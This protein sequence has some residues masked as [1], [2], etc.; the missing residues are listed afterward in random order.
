MPAHYLVGAIVALAL[1]FY[2]L[3]AMLAPEKFG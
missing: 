3:Y 2:L 1:L